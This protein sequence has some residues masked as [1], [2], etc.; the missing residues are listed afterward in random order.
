[1]IL[2]R[3]MDTLLRFCLIH[4]GVA[5]AAAGL[6]VHDVVIVD[7]ASIRHL[8][9]AL[10]GAPPYRRLRLDAHTGF[11]A[12]CN[13]GA[14]QAPADFYLFLNNDVLLAR[15]A[16]SAM[17]AAMAADPGLGICGSRLMFP[18]GTIQHA[19]V[20]MAGPPGGPYHVGRRQPPRAVSVSRTD[21]QAVTG[22]CA[23]VRRETFEALG[24][25]DETFTFG[26]EDVDLCLRARQ[27]GWRV[28]CVQ[29]PESLHF[30]SMTPGRQAL[31]APTLGQ[32]FQ[33]WLGRYTI[34][35]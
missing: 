7:N 10:D 16:L 1:M 17:I 6:P 20:L 29:A 27:A 14:T 35:G 25:F 24:G 32:F 18:D 8:P 15:D 34:D 2:S 31:G 26:Y 13:R 3:D 4:L 9:A 21:F 22:A 19:G 5:A 11:S 12:A 28:R 33:R 30:E 23:L